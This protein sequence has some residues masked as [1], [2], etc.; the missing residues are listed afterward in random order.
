MAA[1]CDFTDLF[2]HGVPRGALRNVARGPV[3]VSASANTIEL[4]VHGL[5]T[6]DSVSFRAEAGGS[7][8]SPLV[9]GTTYYAIAVSES[10]FSVAATSGG[11]AI[12]LTD[13]GSNVLVITPLPEEACREWASRLVDDMLPA[14]M[15]PLT[16]PYPPIVRFTVAELAAG[17]LLTLTGAASKSVGDILDAARV[18]LARWA[19]GVPIRGDNAPAAANLAVG[20]T[21]PRTDTSGWRTYGGL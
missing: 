9:S 8:P 5:A 18:R 11:S 2:A 10:R 17:K 20:V 19:K 4:D 7:V 12:D 1:Y 16:S 14:G 6:G 21:A 15:V 13:A 3:S